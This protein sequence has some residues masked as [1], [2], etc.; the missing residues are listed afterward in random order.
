MGGSS[1]VGGEAGMGG[2]SDV[3]AL[4]QLCGSYRAASTGCCALASGARSG[5]AIERSQAGSAASSSSRTFVQPAAVAAT[6]DFIAAG[7]A[8]V[9]SPAPPSREQPERP[10]THH[11]G[12]E[13][14]EAEHLRRRTDAARPAHTAQVRSRRGRVRWRRILRAQPELAGGFFDGF[15]VAEPAPDRGQFVRAVGS[16]AGGAGVALG[17]GVGVGFGVGTAVGAAVGVGVGVACG[18]D[19]LGLLVCRAKPM[20]AWASSGGCWLAI[21]GA[22]TMAVT[23]RATASE[24]DLARARISMV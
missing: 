17:F 24:A 16:G 18:W 22:P 14:G 4:S 8:F 11:G 12:Q 20:A 9:R 21:A 5:S 15:G 7:T 10:K 13:C 23:R 1:Q 6:L 2:S 19:G 3:G